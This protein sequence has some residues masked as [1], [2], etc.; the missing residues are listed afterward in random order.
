MTMTR[1]EAEDFV[2][3][4]Y[5]KAEPQMDYAAPDREKRHPEYTRDL[6]RCV[7]QQGEQDRP[8]VPCIVI[9]GSKGKGSA[10]CM[11]AKILQAEYRVGLMTS[12]HVTDFRERFRVNGSMIPE[13]DF[14]RIMEEIRPDI[15]A[16]QRNIVPGTCISPMGIQT[17]L[18]L[19]YFSEQRTQANVMECGKGARFDDVN[20][21][22]HEYSVINSIFL[23]HTRELGS[24]LEEIASDKACIITGE[25]KAVFIGRQKDEVLEV[26]LR[27][28][29]E[30]HVSAYCA[31]RDF[32]AENIRFTK[33]G[34][35][36]DA[37]FRRGR[38]VEHQRGLKVPLLGEHQAHNLVLALAACRE[39]CGCKKACE[40]ETVN[41]S[42]S[43]LHL[44]GRME[45][46][47]KKPF[48]ILDACINR[49]SA[50]MVRDVLN[51]LKIDRAVTV[52]AVPEDKDYLGIAAVMKDLSA[53]VLLTGSHNPHYHF[54]R[55][56]E[57]QLKKHGI[58][59]R[60][61]E[62]LQEA[63][64]EAYKLAKTLAK[65]EQGNLPVVI[66][67]TTSVITELHL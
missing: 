4:S 56:Q 40:K 46:Y 31:G 41:R 5:L 44:P 30:L 29:R 11:I 63:V 15:D 20:N 49:E 48:T 67:G 37:W 19:R 54:S 43:D 38:S 21:A 3:E 50:G 33:E 9:T 55:A 52:I 64:K 62:D 53:A 35:M 18:A 13:E 39:I 51:H 16:L 24:T 47:R 2:Y 65:P 12:P 6:I 26:L 45:I 66:L 58:E 57:E 25:Q 10:A 14:A 7:Q 32:G 22:R 23:E 17:V 1:Q 34:M 27:R 8:E 60:Y 61:M 59:S 42:L 28:A 36:L